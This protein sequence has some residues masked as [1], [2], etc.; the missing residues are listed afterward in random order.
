MYASRS[1]PGFATPTLRAAAHLSEAC[2]KIR[3]GAHVRQRQ[4][5]AGPLSDHTVL[6]D[7]VAVSDILAHH[8]L[9][10]V[11]GLPQ[12]ESCLNFLWPRKSIA[13]GQMAK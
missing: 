1:S 2:W 10:G 4:T 12:V 3:A 8:T 11:S 5:T 13:R 6:A 9:V 7:D